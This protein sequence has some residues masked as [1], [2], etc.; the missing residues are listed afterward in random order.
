MY[1]R[2]DVGILEAALDWFYTA[3]REAEAFAVLL[4]GFKDGGD[5]ATSVKAALA[6]WRRLQRVR[7][8]SFLSLCA[9]F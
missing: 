5:D 1:K 7:N 6:G 9:T 2:Q 4:A 8:R 3:E